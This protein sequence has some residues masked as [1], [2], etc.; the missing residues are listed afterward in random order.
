MGDYT[1][2][3]RTS[4]QPIEAPQNWV[5]KNDKRKKCAN[6]DSENTECIL[7]EGGGS[8]IGAW[9]YEEYH[10]K[11]CGFFTLYETDYDS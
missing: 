6:C 4:K 7:F 3:I 11:D 9:F 8:I 5:V 1:E 2:N 10:C